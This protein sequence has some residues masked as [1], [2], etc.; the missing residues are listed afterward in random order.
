MTTGAG[1]ED[2]GRDRA[3]P[4]ADGIDTGPSSSGIV[5]PFVMTAGRTRAER[6]DMRVETMLEVADGVDPAAPEHR[7]RPTEQQEI[8]YACRKPASVAE[9]ANAVGLPV[10][11]ITVVAADLVTDGLIRVHHADPVEIELDALQRIID[12]VRAL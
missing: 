4:A 3:S 7:L 5:R 8:L 11:V 9:V 12:K 2:L 10:G 1:G 6:R